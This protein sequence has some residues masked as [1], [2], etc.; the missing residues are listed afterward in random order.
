MAN[1]TQ[2][3]DLSLLSD[4]ILLFSDQLDAAPPADVAEYIESA[5]SD[6]QFIIFNALS[7][8]NAVGVFEHLPLRLQKEILTLLPSQR[9]AYLL[10]AVSPD[11]RT[12]LLAELPPDLV[13]LLLKYLSAEERAI[14]IRLL[15]Y[16]E[17][18]VGR[19]MTPDYIAVR[20]E[21]TARQILDYVRAKGKDSETIN[22]IYCIDEH[23]RLLDD[24]RIRQ[25]LLAPPDH[26]AS[27]L[28]DGM[29]VALHVNDDQEEAIQTFRKYNRVALPVIDSKDILLGIVTFDDIMALSIAADTADIQMIGGVKALREPYLDI[30][31]LNLMQKRSSWLILLFLGEMLTASAMGFYQHEIEQAVVLALFLPLIISSGGNAGSQASTLIIRSLALGEITFGDW[32]IVMRREVFSGIFLGL[33]LGAMGFLR[34][35]IWGSFSDVYGEHYI[36]MATTIFLSLVG[37]VMWGTLSGALMPIFLH[38]MGLDPA[39][40]SAP[41]VATLVDVTGLVIYFSIAMFVLSGTML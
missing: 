10:N 7:P 28:A 30:P 39:V 24:F 25:I 31:F 23:G 9:V 14:S 20:M 2:L 1:R 15:G 19:L 27:D 40:S 35:S 37:V 33:L 3:P 18:S 6:R 12:A 26:L 22:V 34:V 36:M 13:N 11:D 41:L 21:W 32:W 4:N 38:R 29:F 17:N 8:K 5:P 16:P